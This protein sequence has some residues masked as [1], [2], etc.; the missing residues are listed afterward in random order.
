ML[1]DLVFL[2][3]D[4]AVEVVGEDEDGQ[5]DEEA[6]EQVERT[7]ASKLKQKGVIFGVWTNF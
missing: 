1:Q 6:P 3:D 4:E 7:E 5:H 2:N